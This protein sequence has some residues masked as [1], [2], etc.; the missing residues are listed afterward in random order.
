MPKARRRTAM[1]RHHLRERSRFSPTTNSAQTL[2]QKRTARLVPNDKDRRSV[3]KKRPEK[4]S[5]CAFIK[6]L[7][8]RQAPTTNLLMDLR[9]RAVCAVSDLHWLNSPVYQVTKNNNNKVYQVATNDCTGNVRSHLPIPVGPPARE[10]I[11][12]TTRL[13]TCSGISPVAAPGV[14]FLEVMGPITCSPCLQVGSPCQWEMRGNHAV[15]FEK[16]QVTNSLAHGVVRNRQFT[17]ESLLETRRFLSGAY[18]KLCPHRPA[19]CARKFALRRPKCSSSSYPEST[20]PE[21]TSAAAASVERN[22]DNSG[23]SILQIASIVGAATAFSKVL[24]MLRETTIAAAFGVGPVADAFGYA[25]MLPGLF[26]V[27]L[28]GINGPFHSAIISVL[29]KRPKEEG[30][31][32]VESVS[33]LVTLVL[34]VAT[35]AI[36]ANAGPLIDLA[37][38]GLLASGNTYGPMVRSIAILQLRIMAPCAVLSG[39][40]GVGFGTLSAANVYAL[41]SLSPS[42]SSLSVL[43]ASAVYL[44]Y[45]VSAPHLS[46]VARAQMGGVLLAVGATAGATL[47]WLA[48]AVIMARKGLGSFRPRFVNP[49]KDEGVKEVM[50]IMLPATVASGMMQIATYTDLYFASF[51]PNAAAGLGYANL[52]VQAPLGI[53]SSALLVPIL[54]LFAKHSKPE[55][56]P[57]LKLRIRQGVVLAAAA[58]LPITSTF[59]PLATPLVQALFQRKAFDVAATQLVS[60]LVVCYAAGATAFLVRDVLVRAFYGLGDGGPPFLVSVGAIFANVALDWLMVQRLGFG[61]EGL[62]MATTAVNLLSILALLVMLNRKLGGLGLLAWVKPACILLAA[63]AGSAV[64]TSF[65][66]TNLMRTALPGVM[67]LLVTIGMSVTGVAAWLPQVAV[68]GVAGLSGAMAFGLLLCLLRLPEIEPVVYSLMRPK[69]VVIAQVL[70]GAEGRTWAGMRRVPT[71]IRMMQYLAILS[72]HYVLV[73]YIVGL[74]LICTRYSICISSTSLV[75]KFDAHA[76]HLASKMDTKKRP[77]GSDS[78]SYNNNEL[79]NDALSQRSDERNNKA[80]LYGST[81]SFRGPA[82]VSIS[83]NTVDITVEIGL[84]SYTYV[85]NAAVR[86]YLFV[87]QR[88][89]NFGCRVHLLDVYFQDLP[90]TSSF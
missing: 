39:L 45:F 27:L 33:T 10:Y 80:F 54:P 4:G 87:D 2:R 5:D 72:D 55:Q 32:L 71:D 49:L 28:G 85:N 70:Y 78:M 56:W 86:G 57:E 18:L 75:S 76:R 35:A 63:T 65:V 58:A 41:P 89:E 61:A 69:A 81:A 24:G 21:T 77:K 38:P 19:T 1:Q 62:I 26:I 20:R 7:R 82:D 6:K 15:A 11:P 46:P 9:I 53:L 43:A 60:S 74:Q 90:L 29:S 50:A 3:R 22:H 25:G 13:G 52:L 30:A 31:A 14:H 37:A 12:G 67:R 23:S 17:R 51:I 40:I 79:W 8:G 44:R 68:V 84:S 73:L 16:K 83:I 64:V 66:Y 36:V 48:Q 34:L 47:Q 88:N 42:L 59:G